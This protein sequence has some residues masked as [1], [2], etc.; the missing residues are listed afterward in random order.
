M[1]L[2]AAPSLKPKANPERFSSRIFRPGAGHRQIRLAIR[3]E[4]RGDERYGGGRGGRF[5]QRVG[6]RW[7]EGAVAI[8]QQDPVGEPIRLS[9]SFLYWTI[10]FELMDSEM[11]Q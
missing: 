10:L 2:R 3:I 6:D 9:G 8:A 7:L 1:V 5:L 11:L 4:V